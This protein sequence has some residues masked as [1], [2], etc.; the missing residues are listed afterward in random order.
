M[1]PVAEELEATGGEPEATALPPVLTV[2]EVAVVLRVDRKT[3]YAAVRDGEIPGVRRVGRAIRLHRDT[4]LKW[5]AD[6]QGRVPHSRRT[7]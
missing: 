4:V 2:D 3:V 6:G 1:R 7:R 5:L